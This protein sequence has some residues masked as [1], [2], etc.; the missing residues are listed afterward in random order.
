MRCRLPTDK[1]GLRKQLFRLD[2]GELAAELSSS[3]ASQTTELSLLRESRKGSDLSKTGWQRCW[4]SRSVA[5]G[6]L[7]IGL[8]QFLKNN[9]PT[10]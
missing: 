10:T 1:I 3:I 7:K 5:I 2:V 4:M 6:C 8:P 9:F